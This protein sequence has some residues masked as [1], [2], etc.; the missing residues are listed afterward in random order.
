MTE[1]EMKTE[2]M[3]EN[4]QTHTNKEQMNYWV[5]EPGTFTFVE[6]NELIQ[7]GNPEKKKERVGWGRHGSE[8]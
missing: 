7:L 5:K 2:P 8:Y 1:S 4:T 6:V 3:R